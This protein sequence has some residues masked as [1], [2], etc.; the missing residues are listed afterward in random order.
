MSAAVGGFTRY[1]ATHPCPICGG[2]ELLPRGRGIRCEGYVTAS[3]KTANCTRDE[4]A[5]SLARDDSKSPAV[6]P[7]RLKGN[8]G[9]GSSHGAEVQRIQRVDRTWDYVDEKGTVLFQVVK[10]WPKDFRQRKP[11][12]KGG[13]INNVKGVRQ[14]PYRLI[15][16]LVN[17]GKRGLLVCEGEKDA[18]TA[19]DDFG[20]AATTNAMGAGKWTEQA[21][22]TVA[23]LGWR[24]LYIVPH[25]DFPDRHGHLA[26]QEGADKTAALAITFGL[27]AHVL[28]VL[29][30][31]DGYDLTDWKND[32]HTREELVE[33]M[34]ATKA[35]VPPDAP[36]SVLDLPTMQPQH[37]DGADGN[38][39]HSSNGYHHGPD[40]LPA[41]TDLRNAERLVAANPGTIRKDF[42]RGGRKALDGWRLWNGIRWALDEREE[43]MIKAKAVATA[44]PTE[45]DDELHKETI[46]RLQR[47]ALGCESTG[48]LSAM[49]A[50]AASLV[51]ADHTTWD[52]DPYLLNCQNGTINLRNGELLAHNPERFQA[53]LAPVAYDPAMPTPVWDAFLATIFGGDAE[54]IAFVQRG[55]GMS[56]V[57]AVLEH[58]LFV[59]FGR[60]Q[61][62]K[63]T[64][65]EVWLKLLGDYSR[66]A[67]IEIFTETKNPQHPTSIAEL[68]GVRMV[69]TGEGRQG[70]FDEVLVKM[71]TGGDMRNARFMFQDSFTY[72]PS[73]TFWLATNHE[74]NISSISDGIKRRVKM[75][76][77]TVRVPDDEVDRHLPEKLRAEFPGILAWAVRG[78]VAWQATGLG[79]AAAVRKATEAYWVDMDSFQGFLDDRCVVGP[80][81]RV[82]SDEL[83][84]AYQAWAE[85]SGE[86]AAA[87]KW[88]GLR[89]T[90]RGF[91]R[92]KVGPNRRWHWFGLRLRDRTDL[93]DGPDEDDPG[94]PPEEEPE[95]PIESPE[96]PLSSPVDCAG[97]SE[98]APS[99]TPS[100]SNAVTQ[101]DKHEPTRIDPLNTKRTHEPIDPVK[102]RERALLNTDNVHVNARASAQV[103]GNGAK[104]SSGSS[105]LGAE[106]YGFLASD[107]PNFPDRPIGVPITDGVFQAYI[108]SRVCSGC[109]IENITDRAFKLCT[110]CSALAHNLASGFLG[111]NQWRG[112]IGV[113]KAAERMRAEADA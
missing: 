40:G 17:P 83:Y 57:G 34:R 32:G 6:Y 46:K 51:P 15:E 47:E 38:G 103:G 79:S 97:A 19:I 64:F 93:W 94:P 33:I 56:L 5:G 112:S 110:A 55:V 111:P 108:D 101:P 42:T 67:S 37:G 24:R 45:I 8:C 68:A 4:Q 3:G 88:F 95:L 92:K 35:W 48:R 105:D 54:L 60:G 113:R 52:A 96:N 25:N 18:D 66:E 73:D 16:L 21:M 28:P 2:H 90:E 89:L 58:V 44:L 20:F 53:K 91:T 81:E 98:N 14:V 77:F 82:A 50:N 84:K 27:Q 74:P 41:F 106:G 104:G 100:D 9:C 11:D 61:N 13:W 7:H 22:R 102:A 1:N 63:S 12:G 109:G 78:C 43:M 30:T 36:A 87:Q 107:P 86:K 10:M 39:W 75:I 26:G 99:A 31:A 29:G 72:V 65:L 76:P 62:G 71:L 80:H 59:L 85:S 69:M 70:R 49:V 23:E